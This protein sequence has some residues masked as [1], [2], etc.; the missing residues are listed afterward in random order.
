MKKKSYRPSIFELGFHIF[1]KWMK[2]KYEGKSLQK[3]FD[4]NCIET[5]AIYGLGALGSRLYEDLQAL[6]V[7]VG[8]AID[9]NADNINIE[10]LKVYTLEQ[11]LPET[12]AIIITPVQF[13]CDIECD[14]DGKTDADIISLEDVVEYC[15]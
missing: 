6:D 2:L 8:Y 10:G 5:V 12:D 3:Y 11:Q 14:L 1:D 7:S 4:D 13:F 9:R 15:V